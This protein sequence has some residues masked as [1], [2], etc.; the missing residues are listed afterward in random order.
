MKGK[1]LNNPAALVLASSPDG[2][3]AV[4]TT[5]EVVKNTTSVIPFLIKTAVFVGLG[6][7][8]YSILTNRFKPILENKSYP[9]ANVTMGQ[10]QTR[11]E[12]IYTAMK[13]FGANFNGVATNLQGLN[14]NGWVRVYNAFGKRKGANPLAESIDLVAWLNDQFNKNELNLLRTLVGSVF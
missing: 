6:Y 1:G 9:P 2:Q 3:K 10:A 7:L 12:A 5:A 13:G 14:Y 8:A 4:S 11:A